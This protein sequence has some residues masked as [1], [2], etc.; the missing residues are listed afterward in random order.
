MSLR[1]GI[2]KP[3]FA[4][5]RCR[6]R[7]RACEGTS[8]VERTIALTHS[9]KSLNRVESIA[10]VLRRWTTLEAIQSLEIRRKD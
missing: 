1:D 2:P 7:E 6:R 10:R 5:G 8:K 3:D 4:I 9:S